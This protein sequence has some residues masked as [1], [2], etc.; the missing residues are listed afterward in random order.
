MILQVSLGVTDE[1]SCKEE[2]QADTHKKGRHKNVQS[3]DIIY[4]S[5]YDTELDYSVAV[6]P[7]NT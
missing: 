5:K 1:R 2:K 6:F 7:S 4:T 3:Y